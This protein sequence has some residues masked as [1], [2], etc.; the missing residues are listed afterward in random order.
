MLANSL[1]TGESP[2]IKVV[3]IKNETKDLIY[4]T[5]QTV[6]FMCQL[7]VYVIFMDSTVGLSI[8]SIHVL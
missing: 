3:N 8:L 5:Q 2:Y 4:K 7:Q 1:L 6:Q